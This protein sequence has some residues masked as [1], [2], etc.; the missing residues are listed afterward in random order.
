MLNFTCDALQLFGTVVTRRLTLRAGHFTTEI[1][2]QNEIVKKA[3]RSMYFLK[4]IEISGGSYAT[5]QGYLSYAAEQGYLMKHDPLERN[6][7]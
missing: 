2:I 1:P 7:M 6:A 4:G 3:I 5:E